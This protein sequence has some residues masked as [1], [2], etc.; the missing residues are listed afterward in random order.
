MRSLKDLI[1][2]AIV[3][4]FLGAA[5]ALVLELLVAA[6]AGR[7]ADGTSTTALSALL[8]LCVPA[9][10][11]LYIRD[12]ERPKDD[13]SGSDLHDSTHQA[14]EELRDYLDDLAQRPDD[15]WR[16]MVGWRRWRLSTS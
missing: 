2:G 8:A 9:L 14:R 1:P 6:A 11:T 7:P 3:L 10:V 12:S 16:R 13:D 5:A 15:R 4:V